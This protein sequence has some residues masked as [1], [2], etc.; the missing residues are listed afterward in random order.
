VVRLLRTRRG[1]NEIKAAH[2]RIVLLAEFLGYFL[3][4]VV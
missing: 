2:V 1:L 4:N 3:I